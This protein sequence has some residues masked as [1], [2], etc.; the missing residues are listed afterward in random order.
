MDD[1]QAKVAADIG[2]GA[3]AL[4]TKDGFV[5]PIPAEVY[6]SYV[7]AAEARKYDPVF[8]N[9][10]G[11]DR[12][13]AERLFAKN[14][15]VFVSLVTRYLTLRGEQSDTEM[16]QRQFQA[17]NEDVTAALSQLHSLYNMFQ[18]LRSQSEEIGNSREYQQVMKVVRDNSL[19]FL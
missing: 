8:F 16:Y 1:E 9:C 3:G 12:P 13:Q 11:I 19:D 6:R 15:D 7:K 5:E 18:D 2:Y 17:G 4:L 14:A 10:Y